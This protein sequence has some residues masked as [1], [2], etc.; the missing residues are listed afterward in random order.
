[1]RLQDKEKPRRLTMMLSS[2]E[3][4]N[5][6]LL[7][8]PMT[9][10][11][12]CVDA[13]QAGHFEIVPPAMLDGQLSQQIFRRPLTFLGSDADLRLVSG[14]VSRFVNRFLTRPVTQYDIDEGDWLYKDFNAGGKPYPW[15]KEM[16]ERV[17]RE[18]GGRLPIVVTAIPDGEAHYVGEP[19]AQIWTDEPGMGELVG[20]VESTLLP[21]LYTTT[22]V[23]T[24]GRQRYERM[25]KIFKDAYPSKS[26]DDI[27]SM[28]DYVCHDFGRR[29]AIDPVTSGVACLYNFLGTDTMDA[30]WYA[31]RVLNGG[32]KFGAC[33]IRA[34]AHRTVTPWE[35]EKAA[36]DKVIEVWGGEFFSFVADTYDYER[37]VE[38]LAGRAT[39]IQTAGGLLVVR[40]DSGDPV[41][42]ILKAL[43]ILAKN[44]GSTRNEKGLLEIN[45]AR[46]IQG[47]GIND[48]IVFNKIYPALLAAGYSPSNLALGMG[49]A[50][51]EAFRSYVEAAFKTALVRRYDGSW[52]PVMK[53][54]EMELKMSVSGAVMIDH[55]GASSGI[56]TNR[57]RP[58]TMEDVMA[59][60]T[61][62]LYCYFD[63]RPSSR[64]LP[65]YWE[66]FKD[67]RARARASWRELPPNPDLD[68][69]DPRIRE[70][71]REITERMRAA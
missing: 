44:F 57:V 1:M 68:T 46:V 39:A 9:P 10:M 7:P 17:V 62:A 66:P 67:T 64:A 18:Y 45:G 51:H 37:C 2:A 47:D 32:E 53:K 49:Q 11:P 29:G 12:S 33:S 16:F 22:V 48:D 19:N 71:Q 56:Y 3:S 50:N 20:W 43:R 21:N 60:R 42:C 25:F 36:I 13:Y 15:P 30:A 24:R 35:T 14:G 41:E 5:P 34:A 26:D 69:F 38:M 28:V 55:S 23:A 6:I 52:Y 27:H 8:P 40:P 54:S 31:T 63:G 58:I 65:T 70:M 59:A 61:G 4:A